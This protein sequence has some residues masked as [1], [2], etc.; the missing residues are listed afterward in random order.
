MNNPI[1]WFVMTDGAGY[2]TVL[3]YDITPHKEI[4]KAQEYK[5]VLN[6]IMNR[7]NKIEEKLGGN[8]NESNNVAIKSAANPEW[9]I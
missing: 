6:S 5:D 3:P 9:N 1:V 4:D 2:K 8:S 7:L